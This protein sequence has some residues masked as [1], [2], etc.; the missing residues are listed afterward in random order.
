MW[1]TYAP[2]CQYQL[3]P[4]SSFN[5]SFIS[6]QKYTWHRVIPKKAQFNYCFGV[7]LKIL[8]RQWKH[9]IVLE[10]W[11]I[12]GCFTKLNINNEVC[13]K[14]L[15]SLQKHVKNASDV[16]YPAYGI[17]GPNK[18]V[19]PSGDRRL[20]QSAQMYHY[21]HQ[22]QQII[23]MERWVLSFCVDYFSLLVKSK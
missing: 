8:A 10:T 2:I 16:E 12:L 20:A 19:S 9:T 22:K 11:N 1:I 15:F 14:F 21:Q 23:A 6:S 18:D 7:L 5:N 13:N 17:T 3:V 4:R